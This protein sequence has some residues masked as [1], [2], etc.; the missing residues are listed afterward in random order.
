MAS[1]CVDN[2][3]G[4]RHFKQWSEGNTYFSISVESDA[5][6]AAGFDARCVWNLGPIAVLVGRKAGCS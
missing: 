1:R 5:M 4:D 3:R 6:T 2:E